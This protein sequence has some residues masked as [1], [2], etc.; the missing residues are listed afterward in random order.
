[1]LLCA[2]SLTILLTPLGEADA[3]DLAQIKEAGTL[4]VATSP[5]YPPQSF[6]GKDGKLEGFDVDVAT[7]IAKRIGV[8]V[9]FVTPQWDLMTAGNWGD[10]WD[11]AVASIKKKKKRAAVLKFHAV[12]YYEQA[13]AAVHKDSP[14]KSVKDL[15]GKA[16]GVTGATLYE[17][18]VNKKLSLEFADNIDFSSSFNYLIDD[19]KVVTYEDEAV[20]MD[21]L[22]L[23]DGVRLN[24]MLSS[25]VAVQTAIA[26][27]YPFRW[28]DEI[29]FSLPQA[30]A[31][32]KGNADLGAAIAKA[33]ADMHADGTL[34]A[35]S[36]KWHKTDLTNPG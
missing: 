22:R 27:G 17:D 34:A 33:V 15:S 30:I 24:A 14:F 1:L 9:T 18:Y 12:Y 25:K 16:V 10:R 13:V 35:L 36:N 26:N 6:M 23:G 20:S 29:I 7:E 4:V 3:R 28:L 8:K 11:V 21:D 2:A 19:A 5:N 32:E 31:V